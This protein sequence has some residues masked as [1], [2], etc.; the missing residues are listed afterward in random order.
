[1]SSTLE[2]IQQELLSI[3]FTKKLT[4]GV[5]GAAIVSAAFFIG[6][7]LAKRHH[8][9]KHFIRDAEKNEQVSFF[10]F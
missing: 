6:Y 9:K 5:T 3:H 7:Q 1:M 4:Y 8:S 2:I 10:F